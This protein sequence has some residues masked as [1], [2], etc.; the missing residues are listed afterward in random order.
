[1][2]EILMCFSICS[3]Q[4]PAHD[5]AHSLMREKHSCYFMPHLVNVL[6]S[7]HISKIMLSCAPPSQA[8]T[9]TQTCFS[10]IILVIS[11]PKIATL[12]VCF[13]T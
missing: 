12:N 8:A 11:S 5:S 4:I 6:S 2:Q 1:M 9:L 7:S 3:K 13:Q 10:T